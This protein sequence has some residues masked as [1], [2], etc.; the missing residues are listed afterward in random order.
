MPDRTFLD[1]DQLDALFNA[2]PGTD[3]IPVGTLD[4]LNAATRDMAG[5]GSDIALSAVALGGWAYLGAPPEDIALRKRMLRP[6]VKML[7]AAVSAGITDLCEHSRQ[8]R[9]VLLYCDPPSLVCLEPACLA[10]V[11][12][13]AKAVGFR[14]DNHC[15]GCG[16]YTKVVTPYLTTLGPLSLSGHLC[17]ACADAATND[18][19]QA[20]DEVRPISR[21]S[22]CPC[23]SGRR[24]KRCHGGEPS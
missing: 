9:P 11:D 1:D 7:L 16:V 12:Q 22:P 24:F 18:V 2:M 15:D 13:H 23:G 6:V 21:K 3:T 19:V 8:I 20:A 10:K 14:W 4:Q 5:I 17:Q